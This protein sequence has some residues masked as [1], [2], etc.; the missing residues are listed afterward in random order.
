[1]AAPYDNDAAERV[2]V[3][4]AVVTATTTAHSVSISG[5]RNIK[6]GNSVEAVLILGATLVVSL[7]AAF[8]MGFFVSS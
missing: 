4:R 7:G 2:I 1:L 3:P 8:L 6:F 5:L